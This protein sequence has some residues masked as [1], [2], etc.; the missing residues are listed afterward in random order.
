VSQPKHIDRPTSITYSSRLLLVS[1]VGEEGSALLGSLISRVF[2][3]GSELPIFQL[4]KKSAVNA[5]KLLSA[6]GYTN[7]ASAQQEGSPWER[8]T[9]KASVDG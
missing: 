8:A 9:W 1:C 4:S 2:H 5:H 3:T 6:A 7:C